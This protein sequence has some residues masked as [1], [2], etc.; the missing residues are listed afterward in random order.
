MLKRLRAAVRT[1]IVC[2]KKKLEYFAQKIFRENRRNTAN[3][4]DGQKTYSF[5]PKFLC[6]RVSLIYNCSTYIVHNGTG[7]LSVLYAQS[8][9][10]G[11]ISGRISECVGTAV[12]WELSNQPTHNLLRRPKQAVRSGV[13]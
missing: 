10:S 11:S 4:Q 9:P 5:Q 1:Q 3:L 13:H 2:D 7:D 12:R 6:Y 8:A